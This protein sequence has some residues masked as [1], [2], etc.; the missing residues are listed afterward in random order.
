LERTNPVASEAQHTVVI[1]FEHAL[2]GEG[3][4]KYL[5]AHLGVE[6]VVVSA[7]DSGAAFAAL[8]AGPGVVIFEKYPIEQFDLRALA[9]DAVLIDVS[10]V[11]TR[12]FVVTP[13]VA[14]F[15]QI[16]QAVREC[17]SPVAVPPVTRTV[18]TCTTTTRTTKTTVETRTVGT[19]VAPAC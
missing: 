12:G 10:M 16:L 17:S 6:A 9:P 3:I 19:S 7:H 2:L 15:E 5:L 1:L 18:K 8:V 14:G 11:V 13:C 4:A